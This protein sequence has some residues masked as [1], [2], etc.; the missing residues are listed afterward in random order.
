MKQKTL[1]GKQNL[2][3]CVRSLW[4][5]GCGNCFGYDRFEKITAAR[6]TTKRHFAP[7]FQRITGKTK[8]SS[9]RW[10]KCFRAS[11]SVQQY[12]VFSLLW[13]SMAAMISEVAI[14][15]F[16]CGVKHLAAKRR[17]D[18]SVEGGIA[19]KDL[20]SNC[21][22]CQVT[23]LF[24]GLFACAYFS[25][26]GTLF[27]IISE[28]YPTRSIVYSWSVN[29]HFFSGIGKVPLKYRQVLITK[30]KTKRDDTAWVLLF[31]VLSNL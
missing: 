25:K 11:R 17:S 4:K 27:F 26:K 2:L 6:T 22:W 31:I 16:R 19:I 5:L 10:H 23:N 8:T 14:C 7:R 3:S 24:V 1:L 15:R 28:V 20:S 29:F 13:S 21:S 9:N 12:F 30:W 18:A